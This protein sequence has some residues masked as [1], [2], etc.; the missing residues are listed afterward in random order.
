M[1]NKQ[2]Q[3]DI[4]AWFYY[5]ESGKAK[6]VPPG[7]NVPVGKS[8]N[9]EVR[10]RPSQMERAKNKGINLDELSYLD[11]NAPPAAGRMVNRRPS[12]QE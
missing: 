9:D 8:N 5:D 2:N 12:V 4:M 10:I 1:M 7:G 3:G 6:Q 11:D